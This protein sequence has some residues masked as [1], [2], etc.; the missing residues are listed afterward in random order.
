MTQTTDHGPPY[1]QTPVLVQGGRR[2]A[3]VACLVR[4]ATAAGLGLGA[5]AVLVM[6]V[7]ISSPYPDNGPDGAL[8]VAA[9]FW[10]LAHGT[11]LVREGTLSGQPAPVGLVP[12]LLVVLPGW[13]IV[14]AARD[15]LVPDADGRRPRPAPWGAVCAVSAGYL[16]VGAVVTLYATG[17]SPAA[18]PLSA[19]LR[20]PLVTVGCAVAGVWTAS[21]SPGGPLPPWLPGPA[22]VRLARTRV[23]VALRSAAAGALVLLGGG[24]L[25]VASALVWHADA[26]Q[27]SFLHLSGTWSGRFAVLLLGIALVPNAAVW[28]AAY[29]LGPGFALGTGSTAT[30]LALTGDPALPGFPLV[31]AIPAEGPGTPLNWASVAVPVLAALVIAWFTA[32]RA[33]P[34]YGERESAWSNRETAR[35]ALLGAVGCAVLMAALAAVA[36]GP[37]GTE[38]LAAFGP[39]WWLTGA[40]ALCWSALIAVPVAVGV[41]IWRVVTGYGAG[42]GVRRGRLRLRREGRLPGVPRRGR[43]RSGGAGAKEP[44]EEYDFLPERPSPSDRGPAP[45]RDGDLGLDLILAPDRIAHPDPEVAVD[46]DPVVAVEHARASDDPAEDRCPRPHPYAEPSAAPSDPAG[47]TAE[48]E[49]AQQPIPVTGTGPVGPGRSGEAPADPGRALAQSPAGAEP[50][51]GSEAEPDSDPDSDPESPTEPGPEAAAAGADRPWA[52]PASPWPGAPG[53]G[54]A[55][56]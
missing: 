2:A 25:L 27:D 19:L 23:T 39:V 8:H 34:R 55:T 11:E 49:S 33:A 37:M 20:L 5:F 48:A 7:W 3:L 50:K 26:A 56:R 14:R 43:A 10:L 46:P 54:T 16:L 52:A 32:D 44:F 15:G 53:D 36:G 28:G 24:A 42:A 35:A 45:E 1:S 12:L 21:H 51:D 4:G 9:A 17:G 41:R 47:K 13:L 38:R 29:G 30:P 6:G 18:D 22:R 31:A 40:A